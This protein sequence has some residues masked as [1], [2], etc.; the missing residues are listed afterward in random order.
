MMFV[1][2]FGCLYHII[3]T[4]PIRSAEGGVDSI[5]WLGKIYLKYL[6]SFFALT[7]C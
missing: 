5:V 1:M 4:Q 6:V 3:K 7:C 2:T